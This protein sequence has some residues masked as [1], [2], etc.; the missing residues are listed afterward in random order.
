MKSLEWK[1]MQVNAQKIHSQFHI[2]VTNLDWRRETWKVRNFIK[3]PFQVKVKQGPELSRWPWG[4]KGK[5]KQT[6]PPPTHM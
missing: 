1:L 6:S 2:R 3:K 4:W 5:I